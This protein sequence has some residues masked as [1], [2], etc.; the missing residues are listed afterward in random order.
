MGT[1][2]EN[3]IQTSRVRDF[4]ILSPN[5]D[6]TIKYHH[7][8]LREPRGEGGRKNISQ[9]GLRTPIKRV[10]LNK[11]DQGSF[12]LMEIEAAYTGT[13]CVFTRWGPRADRRHGHKS[14]SLT[15]K[16]FPMDNHL[17]IKF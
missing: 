5:R 14:L 11:H 8:E 17:Q 13:V 7:S 3:P 16:L 2:T 4:G 10:P 12:E 6:F 1:N 15:Q 9:R